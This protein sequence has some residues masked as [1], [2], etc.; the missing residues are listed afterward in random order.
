MQNVDQTVADSAIAVAILSLGK[1]LRLTVTA[2]GIERRTQLDWLRDRGCHE[3]QGFF[4]SRP[5]TAPRLVEQFL[6]S[7][8]APLI[9]RYTA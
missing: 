5:L 2:E 4:L 6:K 9:R 1:S 7:H 8:G 3:G